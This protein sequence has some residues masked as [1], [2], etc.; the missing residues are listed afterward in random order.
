MKMHP[1]SFSPRHLF[2]L[3][4]LFLTVISCSEDIDSV[5]EET[6]PLTAT[7]LTAYPPGA[8]KASSF[9]FKAGDA[10]KAFMAAINSNKSVIIIDKQSSDWVIGP[11]KFFSTTNKTIIFERGVVLRAKKGAYPKTN[12]SMFT[13]YHPT[14]V[15]V[16]GY[17]ATL[18]MNK[19]EYNTGEWRHALIILG[20]RNVTVKGL[21]IKDS[22]GDGV[23]IH[24]GGRKYSEDITIEDI[25]STNN[26][27]NALTVIS[28]KNVYVR[29][30]EFMYSSGTRPESGIHLE[31]EAFG[32]EL[33]NINF[34]NCKIHHNDGTGF[35][36]GTRHLKSTSP[37]ISVNVK[38]SNFSM[39]VIAPNEGRVET[40]IL[41]N[42]GQYGNPVKGL[43]T[44]SNITF[45]GTK[46]RLFLTKKPDYAFKVVFNNCTATNVTQNISVSPIDL[47]SAP[48][49]NNNLGGIE[50]NNFYIQYSKSKSFMTVAGPK[51]FPLKNITGS[52]TI[53]EP[54]DKPIS[55]IYGISAKNGTNYKVSYKHVN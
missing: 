16:E 38:N 30:S 1:N 49:V 9:G 47:Q 33:T 43:A 22:G 8:V 55:Y 37:P 15:V 11:C 53:K 41:A 28:G 4:L 44:F 21:T 35:S 14:N 18:Q 12:D 23:N 2:A 25:V 42:S 36:L 3:I 54:G 24:P 52:F 13:L 48:A 46:A 40:E 5:Y 17:G 45:N 10:T 50:F 39:N 19:S 7:N 27:R 29:N 31:P 32:Q 26:R 6:A 51:G 20:G 34:E